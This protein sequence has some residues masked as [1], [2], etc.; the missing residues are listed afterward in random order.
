M[1]QIDRKPIT[2]SGK[3]SPLKG[4]SIKKIQAEAFQKANY[5]LDRTT[6]VEKA[7]LFMSHEEVEVNSKVF[8]GVTAAE[9]AT[10]PLAKLA[11]TLPFLSEKT[12]KELIFL[13][14]TAKKQQFLMENTPYED[15]K[16][17]LAEIL[18][19]KLVVDGEDLT[20]APKKVQDKALQQHLKNLCLL[21]P[22]AQ[23]LLKD[24]VLAKTI[25]EKT[26]P[27]EITDEMIKESVSGMPSILRWLTK[28]GKVGSGCF[29][30]LDNPALPPLFIRAHTSSRQNDDV[31][32]LSLIPNLAYVKTGNTLD[33]K[34]ANLI[35]YPLTKAMQGLLK[36]KDGEKLNFDSLHMKWVYTGNWSAWGYHS[37]TGVWL[38]PRG[39]LSFDGKKWNPSAVLFGATWVNR[40]D[41]LDHLDLNP[42]H[43]RRRHYDEQGGTRVG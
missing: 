8:I 16:H 39:R 5:Y 43:W 38:N 7:N 40:C 2:K 37:R 23:T 22:N 6:E 24:L 1:N 35:A 28:Q 9:I 19:L 18:G 11:K 32:T 17:L 20:F 15:L 31:K 12:T 13:T 3:T 29:P 42:F 10:Y 26:Y 4:R 41:H 14:K 33:E 30:D 25:F 34:P 36:G 21:F 27:F